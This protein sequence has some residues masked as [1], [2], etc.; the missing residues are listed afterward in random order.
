MSDAVTIL[1][2]SKS[3]G[4]RAVLS[5]LDLTVP[6]GSIV[7][8]L[9]PNGCGKT[10]MMKILAGMI[11]DYQGEVRIGTTPPSVETKSMVAYL[12]DV[13][14]LAPGMNGW[15]AVRFFS[16]FF[17]D[18]DRDRAVDLLKRFGLDANQKVKTMSKGM[19]EK[20]QLMLVLS[21]RAKLYLLDEPL[22]G[23]DPATRDV[24]LDL[25]LG[26]YAEDSAVLISTQLIGEIERIFDRVVFLRDGKN[27][28]SG[29][30]D[31]L[32]Q[33]TGKSM[34]ALFREVYQC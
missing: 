16:D 6:R 7:G 4:R 26:N 14:F 8:L 19:V 15:D 3:Y 10:T 17:A 31:A 24:I 22:G 21:R 34:D 23:V 30:V 28:L 2:L 1:G 18:F 5:G 25:I 33:Q 20:L 11:R 13:A 29:E 27:F 12:P 32:R 9:G